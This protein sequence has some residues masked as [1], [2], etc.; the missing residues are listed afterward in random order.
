MGSRDRLPGIYLDNV[1][2]FYATRGVLTVIADYRLA[3][4]T[5]YPAPAEDVRDAV[6]FVISSSEVNATGRGAN[7]NQVY[8]IGHS[9]GATHVSTTLLNEDVLTE[10]DRSHIKGI[11]LIAGGYS[12]GPTAA[13]Y[14]GEGDQ[15]PKTPL[16]LL[17][18]KSP[19]KVSESL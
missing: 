12:G 13:P 7:I 3:P 16:G 5:Q 17:D 2:S 19:E 14:Y 6:R 15:V 1:G 10:N 4:V 9:A 8:L 11:I 18:S